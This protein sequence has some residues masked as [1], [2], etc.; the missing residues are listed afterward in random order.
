VQRGV[1]EKVF[2]SLLGSPPPPLPVRVVEYFVIQPS[3]LST[4]KIAESVRVLAIGRVFG[5]HRVGYME[6]DFEFLGARFGGTKRRPL[7]SQ[8]GDS[9]VGAS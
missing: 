6:H 5:S 9:A 3:G 7:F 8:S 2:D 4:S 1:A